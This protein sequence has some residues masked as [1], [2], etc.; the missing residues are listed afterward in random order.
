MN[1]NKQKNQTPQAPRKA[2]VKKQSLK[3]KALRTNQKHHEQE[4]IF[5]RM[6]D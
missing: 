1:T 5:T 3:P 2:G 6:F 4:S